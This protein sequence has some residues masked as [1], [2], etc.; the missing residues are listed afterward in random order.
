MFP[1]FVAN[2]YRVELLTEPRQQF[3]VLAR[4]DNRGGIE[5]VVEKERL[6]CSA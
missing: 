2:R 6:W 5:R 1:D 4:I 3:E